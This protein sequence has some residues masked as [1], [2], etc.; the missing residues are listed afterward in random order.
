MEEFDK[1]EHFDNLCSDEEELVMR[2]VI[3][4]DAELCFLHHYLS[5]ICP[6]GDI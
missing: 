1:S 6:K 5:E 4:G 2:E 3:Q